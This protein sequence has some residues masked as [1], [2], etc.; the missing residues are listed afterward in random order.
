MGLGP[1]GMERRVYVKA[2]AGNGLGSFYTEK[3]GG[4]LR[5]LKMERERGGSRAPAALEG[6]GMEWEVGGPA[7]YGVR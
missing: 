3:L 1:A 4:E 2:K 5:K 6:G 7:V